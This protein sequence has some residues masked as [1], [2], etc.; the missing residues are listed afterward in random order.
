MDE[1]RLLRLEQMATRFKA[2]FRNEGLAESSFI[3][4]ARFR[5]YPQKEI[6]RMAVKV[7]PEGITVSLVEIGQIEL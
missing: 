4:S 6:H 2:I 3:T 5:S 7:W 1:H